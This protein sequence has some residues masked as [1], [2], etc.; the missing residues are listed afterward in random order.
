MTSPAEPVKYLDSKLLKHLVPVRDLQPEHRVLLASKSHFVD[1][2]PGAEV[3]SSEEHRWLLYL[4][5][6]KLEL[7]GRDRE[8]F[9]IDALDVRAHHPVFVE[10]EHRHHAIA[11]T[12]CKLVRFDRQLFNTL[13]EHELL[14]G[15]ELETI[16]VDDAESHLFTTILHAFNLGQLKLPSLPD[17]ALRIKNAVSNPDVLIE[18]VVHVIEAD[19]SI[20]VR[21]LQVV[22]N[23]FNRAAAP[24]RNLREAVMRLGF[25]ETR[26]LVISLSMQQ[27]FKTRNKLLDARMHELYDHSVEV[28]SICYALGRKQSHLNAD[29]LL[30]A[31]LIHDIGVIPILAYVDEVGLEMS[32]AAELDVIVRKLRGV[33]G[34]MVVRH[35]GLPSDFVRV[36]EDAE[37]WSRNMP[38]VLD[39]CDMV[40]VAQIY[41]MLQRHQLNHLPPIDKVPAFYKLFGGKPD[42]V[43]AQQVLKDAHDEV[44][45]IMTALKM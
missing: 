35:W 41:S 40:I 32:S 9:Y 36:T 29:Y 1:L 44:V 22:N 27:L 25:T 37:N 14:S 30:L 23:P 34:S 33:V 8:K 3:V 12:P 20:A 6:G 43:F 45:A 16:E 18:D 19:P 10:G 7:R 31:G 17:I 4:L 38:G 2:A 28:A 11:Q 24:V 26:N 21:M 15:E 5:A 39:T 13:L 42:P